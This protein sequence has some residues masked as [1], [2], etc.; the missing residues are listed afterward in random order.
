MYERSFQLEFFLRG[1]A[2]Q[3]KDMRGKP[4][5]ALLLIL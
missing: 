2:A 5:G 4:H 3:R 1:I